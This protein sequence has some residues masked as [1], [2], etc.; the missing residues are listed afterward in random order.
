MEWLTESM[1]GAVLSGDGTH[2]HHSLREAASNTPRKRLQ[3]MTFAPGQHRQAACFKPGC[4]PQA[5][6]H[7]FCQMV[8]ITWK[9]RVNRQLRNE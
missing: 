6:L 4:M 1:D 2:S 8:H 5:R 3:Q 7:A 9:L